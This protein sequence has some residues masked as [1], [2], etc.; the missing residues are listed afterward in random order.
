MAKTSASR[1]LLYSPVY[2]RITGSNVTTT[3]QT[4][5][6]ITG[7]SVPLLANVTYEFE[8]NLSVQTSADT[9]G[10]RYA[11]Q[12]SVA[13]ATVEAETVNTKTNTSATNQERISA[14]N[15]ATSVASLTTSAITGGVLIKGIVVVGAN[16]GNLTIQ[17][18]KITSGTSTVFINSFLRVT[19]VS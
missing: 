8:A 19:R 16:A 5:I 2:A 12:Y 3:G 7:L 4:L 15:T 11:V 1:T 13:G 10:T 9:T 6:D 14:F 17:H 18:L